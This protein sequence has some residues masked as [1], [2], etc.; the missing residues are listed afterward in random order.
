MKILVRLPNWL[1]DMVMST[2][3]VQAL[4]TE[5]PSA[6]IDVIVKKGLEPLIDFIPGIG[7]SYIFNKEEWKGLRGAY[8]FGRKIGKEIKY[9]LFFC[10]PDSFSSACMAWA[11]G[12]KKR[13]GFKKELRS[14]F[15]TRSFQKPSGLHRVEEYISLLQLFNNKKILSPVIKLKTD[16]HSLPRRII[17]NFNSEAESRKMP[18]TKAA[19][20]LEA[21]IKETPGAELICIGS[22]QQKQHVDTILQKV[23]RASSVINKAGQTQTVADLILL[24]ATASA[25]LTT[26]SGPAHIANALGIPVVVLFGA[27]D[28]KNT[29]PYNKDRLTVL[30]LGQ[31]PCEPC[32]KNICQFGSPKCLEQLDVQKIVQAVKKFMIS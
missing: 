21:I 22:M 31:L 13:I 17:L 5:Y 27:G 12:S 4:Q 11:T 30:R 7:K 18:A 29:A 15:F 8:H 32:V 26:D 16:G 3:F 10:L 14:F 9:D 19:T 24:I 25:M 2:A 1:G 6:E 20:V 23:D 28:E